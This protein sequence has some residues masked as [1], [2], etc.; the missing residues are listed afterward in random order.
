MSELGNKIKM[1]RKKHNLTQSELSCELNK[2]YGLN[3]D[4][5]MISK[6][7]T[8]YQVPIMSSIACIA[9]FFNVSIDY[10]NGTSEFYNFIPEGFI[11]LPPTKK[12]PIV[13]EIACG[14]PIT[15]EQNI[16]GYAD[17]PEGKQADFALICQGDSMIDA[18]IKDGDIVYI[19]KQPE[20]EN[21]QIAAVRINGEATLK[22]IYIN[23]NTIV[24]QPANANYSPLTYTLSD[25]EDVAIEGLAI[26]HTHWF[27]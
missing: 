3:T 13:G 4:R 8:G 7:E 25:L 10:L 21:G 26:G 20:V 1:L 9:K 15:A 11:P 5:V 23:G 19:R 27:E 16:T 18:G 17:M 24:L 2:K 22:R 12:I 6:W 14:T